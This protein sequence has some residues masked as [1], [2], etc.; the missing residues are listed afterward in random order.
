M[1][2]QETKSGWGLM[3]AQPQSS[4]NTTSSQLSGYR[5]V[6]MNLHKCSS[7]SCVLTAGHHQL[8]YNLQVK[9]ARHRHSW[10]SSF[11]TNGTL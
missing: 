10:S 2:K 8:T 5:I 1:V 4:T 9:P 3:D 6:N 11:N 7:N